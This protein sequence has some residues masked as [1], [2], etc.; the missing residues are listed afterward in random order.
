VTL[1]QKNPDGSTEVFTGGR[2]QRDS[3]SGESFATWS[4]PRI[5]RFGT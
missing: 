1:L 2:R 4:A 5:A 3:R